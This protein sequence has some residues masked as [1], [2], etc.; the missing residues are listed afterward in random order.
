MVVEVCV[1]SVEGALEA[2]R[3]GATRLEVCGH[4]PCGGIT[5]SPGLV[6]HIME[7]SRGTG[8]TVHVMVRARAGDFCYTEHEV[9]VMLADIAA[10]LGIEG[11]AG[12]VSGALTL[13]GELDVS[14]LERLVRPVKEVG[15]AFVI[16]RC[17]DMCKDVAGTVDIILSNQILCQTVCG[18]LTSG[19]HRTALEGIETIAAM[20]MRQ[21]G[22]LNIIA[23][24]G[25]CAEN[26][27]VFYQHGVR[28][29]HLSAKIMI[30]S[31]MKHWNTNV[32]MGTKSDEYTI[33]GTSA[34]LV[35][36]VIE[37]LKISTLV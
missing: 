9:L 37:K 25:I 12:I 32:S 31:Q 7:K 1:D 11:V 27:N 15:K 10:I 21:K 34:E 28:T 19:G 13:D 5:P 17:V 14:T 30:P 35:A 8:V 20:V 22:Q 3:G 4:L 36:A 33:Q 2:M 6:Q 24:G 26:V 29:V 23:G 18:I 16:H